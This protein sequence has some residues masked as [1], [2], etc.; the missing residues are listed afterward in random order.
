MFVPP[1][2]E[3]TCVADESLTEVMNK[4]ADWILI[5][6]KPNILLDV[7][8]VSETN[9]PCNVLVTTKI[10]HSTGLLLMLAMIANAHVRP[11]TIESLI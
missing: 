9:T 8:N 5:L 3:Y 1:D 6:S 7:M 11:M 4:A 2:K 10:Y